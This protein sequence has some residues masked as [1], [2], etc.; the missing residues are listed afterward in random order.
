MRA[1]KDYRKLLDAG[2]PEAPLLELV[3]NRYG[4]NAYQR[5][6]LYRGMMPV[7]RAR[8]RKSKKVRS[9]A[10]KPVYVDGFNQLFTIANYILGRPVYIARDGFVRDT[11]ELFGRPFGGNAS[12]AFRKAAAL[13]FLHMAIK[14]PERMIIFL[15]ARMDISPQAERMLR[16]ILSTGN[17]GAQPRGKNTASVPTMKLSRSTDAELRAVRDGVVVTADSRIVENT[18]AGVYD[19]AGAI[20]KNAFNREL[21]D[22]RRLL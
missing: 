7:S 18:R 3:G 9:V 22:L 6:V 12:K 17:D 15:D 11:G 10:G 13:F 19:A 8:S 4:L 5:A 21:P 14:K 16:E 2:Y 20:I 1:A